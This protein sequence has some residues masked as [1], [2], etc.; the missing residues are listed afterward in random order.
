MHRVSPQALSVAAEIR[1]LIIHKGFMLIAILH[2]ENV[3]VCLLYFPPIPTVAKR[4]KNALML[5]N[6]TKLVR[7][8]LPKRMVVGQ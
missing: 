4:Q 1:M 8:K 3:F 6:H 5:I 7:V 2:L